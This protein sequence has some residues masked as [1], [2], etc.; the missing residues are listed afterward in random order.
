MGPTNPPVVQYRDLTFEVDRSLLR[1]LDGDFK[2]RRPPELPST[3][4][5]FPG[6]GAPGGFP[7]GLPPGAE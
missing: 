7:G 5:G 4:Q 3:P 6:G 2:T 1:K